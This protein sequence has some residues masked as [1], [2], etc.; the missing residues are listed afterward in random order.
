MSVLY[1]NALV[2]GFLRCF[3]LLRFLHLGQEYHRG[4]AVLFPGTHHVCHIGKHMMSACL[5]T[6]DVTCDHLVKAGCLPGFFTCKA[7]VF[8]F[9]INQVSGRKTLEDNVNIQFSLKLSLTNFGN[10][11]SFL[12]E[13]N[14]S[15]MVAKWG[16]SNSQFSF[17]PTASGE[18]LLLVPL[19]L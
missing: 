19:C 1:Q 3:L 5:L 6:R 17:K 4:T 11:R 7:T 10:H 14:I 16:F 15:M 18:I 8:P 2:L 9:V 13:S 12:P